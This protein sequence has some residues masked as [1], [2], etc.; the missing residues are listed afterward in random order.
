[1]QNDYSMM[2]VLVTGGAG[3]I[4]SHVVEKLVNCGAHVTV[5]DDLSTGTLENLRGVIS[6]IRF[7]HGT[8]NDLATCI[9]A[10]Q[11]VDIIFHLAAFISVPESTLNPSSCYE[12]NVNGTLHVL[13]AA[14]INQAKRIVFSSSSAVYGSV[15]GA[16]AENTPCRPESPYGHSKLIGE[17]LCCDAAKSG[18]LSTICL[19][20]FNVYGD[21]QNPH[22]Q[23]ASVV[24][25]FKEHMKQ[26]QPVTIYGDGSQ[27]RDFVP[28]ATVV[29]ANLTA[30]I[31]PLPASAF[32]IFN[33][34]TGKSISLL[35]LVEQL[36]GEF[37][38]FSAGVHFRPA[39]KGDIK[40][41]SADCS[42]FVRIQKLTAL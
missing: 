17:L 24:A 35:E 37:P 40:Q 14:E 31:L 8:I 19:R 25:Q 15:D 21:R 13:K 3:F 16:C 39:R 28:V 9:K 30:G 20:Y 18:S 7:I 22:G 33:V 23:Y 12:T 34:G 11:Q 29:Q 2:N 27:T 41:S 38:Q 26:N 1:M 32:E 5:L 10:T 42:K 36:R 4:G 6:E